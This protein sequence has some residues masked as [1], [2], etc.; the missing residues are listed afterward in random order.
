MKLKDYEYRLSVDYCGKQLDDA[1]KEEAILCVRLYIEGEKFGT[2]KMFG[3]NISS[4]PSR[5]LDASI[6]SLD[7]R[8]NR[9]FG[10]KYDNYEPFD[11]VK[12][13]EGNKDLERVFNRWV[14]MRADIAERTGSA[15]VSS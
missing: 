3:V 14:N 9:F 1:G 7:E 6:K 10:N 13:L 8:T 2:F 4:E 15:E 11:L 12:E 5:D